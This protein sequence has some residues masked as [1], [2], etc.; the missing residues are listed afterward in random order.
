[1]VTYNTLAG[2]FTAD[3]YAHRVLYPY[4]DPNLLSIDYRQG[5]IVHELLGYNADVLS[6]Q[7]VGT[8]TFRDYFL[9]ALSSKGYEGC[10]MPKSGSVSDLA[11]WF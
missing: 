7:E 1:M 6:L 11:A 8:D 4:C 3:K 9:P 10:H 5:R 2:A